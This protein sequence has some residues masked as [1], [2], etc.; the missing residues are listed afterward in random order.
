MC[1]IPK[2]DQHTVIRWSKANTGNFTHDLKMIFFAFDLAEVFLFQCI[3][4]SNHNLS[5]GNQ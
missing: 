4:K 3:Y 5:Q 1:V 2:D